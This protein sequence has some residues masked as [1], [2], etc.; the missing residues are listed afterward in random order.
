MIQRIKSYFIRKRAAELK[1]KKLFLSY[2]NYKKEMKSFFQF[3]NK[4]AKRTTNEIAYSLAEKDG[5]RKQPE[6]YWYEAEQ[7]EKNF[8]EYVRIQTEIYE[9][10]VLSTR[11]ALKG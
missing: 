3:L 11:K 4:T 6:E 7:A 5:F 2:V 9:T 1:S 8:K 10:M